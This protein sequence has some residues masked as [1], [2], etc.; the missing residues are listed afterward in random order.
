MSGEHR[1]AVVAIIDRFHKEA[2]E[3]GKDNATTP[4]TFENVRELIMQ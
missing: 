2:Q 1:H 4:W 3:E